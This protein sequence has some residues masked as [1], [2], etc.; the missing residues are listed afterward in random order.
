LVV[1]VQV[2]GVTGPDGDRVE[3]TIDGI[4]HNGLAATA[5]EDSFAADASGV[6][7]T[8]AELRTEPAGVGH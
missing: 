7:T 4:F 1:K 6:G 5:G 8:V 3:I 2:I